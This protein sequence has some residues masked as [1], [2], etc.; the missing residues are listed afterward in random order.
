MN[1]EA[2]LQ[3]VP[4]RIDRAPHQIL[5][6]GR[7]RRIIHLKRDIF[8]WHEGECQRVVERNRL[9]N[10]AELVVII[11]AAAQHVQAQIYFRERAQ[12][13]RSLLS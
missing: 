12:P 9:K 11:R 13:Q 3:F 6:T 1:S 7:Q 4:H 8:F 2:E 10:R 5:R